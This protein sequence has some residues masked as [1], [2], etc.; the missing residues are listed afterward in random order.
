M[1]KIITVI[2]IMMFSMI[3]LA[4]AAVITFDDLE[5]PGTSA[6]VLYSYQDQGFNF[7]VDI[8]GLGYE[9]DYEGFAYWQQ[10][11]EFYNTTASLFIRFEKSIATL[12]T[13]DGSLFTISS[14]DL[15]TFINNNVPC[16]I[17]FKAYDVNDNLLATE[18][19]TLNAGWV[20]F[21]FSSAFSNIDH[22]EW[23]QENKPH[24]FDNVVLNKPGSPVP[25]PSAILLLS[26][27]LIG[28]ITIRRWT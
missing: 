22:M 9:I 10:G 1:K 27:G 7:E 28:L 15:D 12:N 14:I 2:V 6:G 11:N 25:V 4:S 24:Q 23:I 26:S 8:E 19:T 18:G 16:S 20:T 17:E 21:E 5:T 3:S 13:T